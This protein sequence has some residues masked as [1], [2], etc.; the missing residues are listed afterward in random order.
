VQGQGSPDA[1]SQKIVTLAQVDF[2]TECQIIEVNSTNLLVVN[3][4]KK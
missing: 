1:K 4:K 2:K 3:T